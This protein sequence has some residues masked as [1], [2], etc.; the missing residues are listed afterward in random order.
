MLTLAPQYFVPL[1]QQAAK[2]NALIARTILTKKIVPKTINPTKRNASGFLHQT[3][4]SPRV[5]AQDIQSPPVLRFAKNGMIA[6][7][8]DQFVLIDRLLA[9]NTLIK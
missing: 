6:S 7:M 4:V 9:A 3:N 2:T 8:M 5:H 1:M